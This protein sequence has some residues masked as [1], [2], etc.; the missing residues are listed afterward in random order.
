ML[1]EYLKNIPMFKHLKDAQ[2]EKVASRCRKTL[3]KKGATVF[4]KTDTT[5]DLYI[6]LSGRLKAVLIDEDG[7]EIVLAHFGKGTFFGELSLLDG[8]G[9]SATIVA[10]ESSE[11]A[12]LGRDAFLMILAEDSK[13][14]IELISTLVER[15][16]KADEMIESLAFLEVSE[17]L[18]KI[19][20]DSAGEDDPQCKGYGRCTKFTHKELASLVGASRE[21]VSKGMKM[22]ISKGLV[23][24]TGDSILIARDALRL[25]KDSARTFK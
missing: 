24:D 1:V 18:I 3:Y 2:L 25:I 16:R 11:L 13:I 10:D 23:R 14:A 17:R 12:V 5:T 7:D 20:L 4:Y 21:A 19:F 6:V 15:L 9:R 8:K 22:L